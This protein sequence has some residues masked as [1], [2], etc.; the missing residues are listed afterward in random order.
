[1]ESKNTKSCRKGRFLNTFDCNNGSRFHTFAFKR[2]TVLNL[3]YYQNRAYKLDI[4]NTR[5][6]TRYIKQSKLAVPKCKL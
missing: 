4:Y 6:Y 1:M 3:K 2:S 5:L